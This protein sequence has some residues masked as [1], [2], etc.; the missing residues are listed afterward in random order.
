MITRKTL[1]T[2][3]VTL[4]LATVSAGA[5][6]GAKP[7]KTRR[8]KLEI[9]VMSKCPFANKLLDAVT[10][11]AAKLGRRLDL[12][13]NYIGRDEAGELTS[14]H[15][16][17]EVEGDL[18]Q[19]C[20]RKHGSR[21]A[22]LEFMSC[23]RDEWRKIPE[24][25]DTCAEQAGIP[26]KRLR[27]CYEGPQG[28]QLLRRSFARSQKQG[29][30]GSPTTFVNGERYKG[31]RSELSIARAVCARMKKPLPTLCRTIPQPVRVPIA[32]VADERCTERGCDPERFIGF[33]SNSFEGAVV[34]QL[35]YS[36]PRGRELYERSGQQYLPIAVF[37]P[38][39]KQEQ[40]GYER[41]ASRLQ[42]IEGSDDYV[43]PIG[44]SWDP[45][46]EIC[47]DGIDNTADGRVDCDDDQ[48]AEQRVCRPEIPGKLDLFLMSQCPYAAKTL[49]ELREVIA[50]FGN[51]PQQIDL[52]LNYVGTYEN[53]ALKAMHGP[54]EVEENK[55]QLCA[56]R[57]YRKRY[58]Y[59]NYVVCRAR[60][61]RN[62]DWRACVPEG[63]SS[64]ELKDCAA[65]EE[66]EELLRRSF[67]KSNKLG[68]KGSPT[69]LLNNR[70]EMQGRDR[71][72]ITAAFCERNPKSS[73]C[74]D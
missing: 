50:A 61:Y 6:A 69:W 33:I 37:G 36:D 1:W 18:L 11:V 67:E 4:A 15:G 34:E 10:P 29:A 24:G 59:M 40:E 63:M 45:T 53:G 47:D 48:C 57:Y 52:E 21:R 23:Q 56:Q 73:G 3:A 30:T 9:H 7:K 72:A 28:K 68:I 14:M 19:L 74:G 39:V 17:Q 2:L 65:A 25:W 20:A 70:H 5:V 42:Q 35:D 51:D 13:L 38:E 66:G 49:I 44:R 26:I 64:Y 43:Y 32:T 8:V 16:R 22:W 41:L 54:G 62:P 58:L 12:K 71:E 31:G 55:R 27:K 60:D 46:A